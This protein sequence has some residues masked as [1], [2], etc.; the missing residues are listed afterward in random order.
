MR[1]GPELDCERE[2]ARIEEFIRGCLAA[3]GLRHVVL[4]MS[5]GLDSALVA[6]LCTRAIGAENV[7][8][9][10]MPYRTSNPESEAHAMAQSRALGLEPLRLEITDIVQP[11]IDREPGI[12][13]RR[14]GNLMARSR[15][16][17]WFDQAMAWNALVAGTSNR[18]E[19]LLGYFTIYGDG[20]A[21]FEPLWHLYK[22]QVRALSRHVGILEEILHKAPSADLWAGQ[23]DEGELGFTYAEADAILYLATEC[24]LSPEAIAAEGLDPGVVAAILGRMRATEFKRLPMPSLSTKKRCTL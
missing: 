11:F 7:R 24:G 22:A 18:T 5:G 12:S 23:T 1:R 15:M 17:T 3:A 2:C 10:V 4:G 20:A 13:D 9:L 14:K 6:A 8:P 19:Y 21:S 16:M